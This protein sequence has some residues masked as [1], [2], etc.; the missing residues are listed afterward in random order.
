MAKKK[1]IS[2]TDENNLNVLIRNISENANNLTTA[3][4]LTAQELGHGCTP[5]AAASA[6]RKYVKNNTKKPVMLL[7]SQSGAMINTKNTP[8]KGVIR[9]IGKVK[10]DDES[11]G[12]DLLASMSGELSK[13]KRV[14]LIKHI[15]KTL[16]P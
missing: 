16:N 8:R 5:A 9:R 7:S 4:E 15:W 13:T 10:Y 1:R 2:W 6:Y 14:E 3:F 11:T 12:F